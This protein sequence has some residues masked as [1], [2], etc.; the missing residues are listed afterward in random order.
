MLI[1]YKDS[2][3]LSLKALYKPCGRLSTKC[4]NPEFC[5]LCRARLCDKQKLQVARQNDI[6]GLGFRGALFPACHM[7]ACSL[8]GRF[9]LFLLGKQKKW[10]RVWGETPIILSL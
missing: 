3:F 6:V 4:A 9:R 5:G 2:L 8:T 1:G 10:T 7:F